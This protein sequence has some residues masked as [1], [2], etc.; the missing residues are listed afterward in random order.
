[1]IKF[2]EEIRE[3]AECENLKPARRAHHGLGHDSKQTIA[4]VIVKNLDLH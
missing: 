1:M 4:L 2:A 3:F